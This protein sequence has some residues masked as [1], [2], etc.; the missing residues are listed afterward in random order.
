MLLLK[1]LAAIA[2]GVPA[3]AGLGV[4]AT[5]VMVVDVREGGPNG[6]HIV[7]PVPLALA[8][9]AL[10]VAPSV[11]ARLPEQVDTRAIDAVDKVLDALEKAED[12]VLVDVRDKQET[13]RIVKDGGTLRI[14]VEGRREQV[15]VQVPISAA[16][17]IVQGG[18][19]GRFD[20]AAVAAALG[21]LRMTQLVEVESENGDRVSIRV[22]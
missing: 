12:G 7:V 3:L 20:G 14:R 2:I 11:P 5:G 22:F 16:R 9:V 13:V 19:D 21:E 18:R 10:N 15:K 6:T 8:K 1:P 4:A 17:M